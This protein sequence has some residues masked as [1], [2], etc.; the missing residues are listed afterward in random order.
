[1]EGG[2]AN[3]YDYADGDPINRQDLDGNAAVVIAVPAGVIILTG[4]AIFLAAAVVIVRDFCKRYSCSFSMPR[5]PWVRGGFHEA[6]AHSGDLPGGRRTQV[7]GQEG[8]GRAPGDSRGV[9]G[10]REG[11]V[12][13]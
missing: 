3:D 10:L 7:G 11:R 8:Q 12:H 5:F 9:L 2:S 13:R 6:R 4:A 1:M